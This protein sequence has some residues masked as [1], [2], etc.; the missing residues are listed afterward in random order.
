MQGG[1]LFCVLCVRINKEAC[2]FRKK[3]WGNTSGPYAP[4]PACGVLYWM[5]PTPQFISQSFLLSKRGM[6][7]R[8]D[9]SIESCQ[10]NSP[11]SHNQ[12]PS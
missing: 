8:T 6:S 10:F 5:L 7:I 11:P 12:R 9:M 2:Y 3:E 1:S 4:Y